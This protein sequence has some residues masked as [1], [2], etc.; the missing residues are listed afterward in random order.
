VVLEARQA[1]FESIFPLFLSLILLMRLFEI[2][3]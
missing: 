2:F 3:F 1:L